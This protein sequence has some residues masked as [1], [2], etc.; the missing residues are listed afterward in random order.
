MSKG[1]SLVA[2]LAATLMLFSASTARADNS[3]LVAAYG[4]E[5]TSG[6]A[7]ADVTGTNPGTITGATRSTAGRHGSALSFDG[8]N[9]RVDIADSAS[10]DL[11]SGMTLEAW[12]KPTT[13]SDWRTAILKERA[14]GLAYA[15]YSSTDNSRPSAEISRGSMAET[16]GPS[17]LP[18]GTW[19]HLATTYDGANLRLYVNGTAVSSAAAP[20]AITVSTGALRLGGNNVWGEFFSGLIDEVRVYNRAL[21]AS[22]LATDMTTPVAVDAEAPT[23]PALTAAVQTGNDVLLTWTAGTD[24]VGVARYD[25]YRGDTLLTQRA[26]NLSRQWLDFDRPAGTASYRVVAVDAAGNPSPAGTAEATIA[27]DITPPAVELP[28]DCTG[29]KLAH[30]QIE[31][32][33]LVSDEFGTTQVRLELDGQPLHTYSGGGLSYGWNTRTATDGVH[34][35]KAIARDAAGNEGN[36]TC[37]YK[38]F[39]PTISVAIIAPEANATVHGD[40]DFR[41]EV[42]GNGEPLPTDGWYGGGTPVDYVDFRLNSAALRRVAEAPYAFTMSMVPLTPGTFPLTVTATINSAWA[43]SAPVTATTT[44]TL[45]RPPAPT[46]VTATVVDDNDVKLTWDAAPAGYGIQYWRV[47]RD[48]W[49]ISSNVS[50]RTF[51]DTD[52][53]PGTYRYTV[54]AGNGYY[55]G[56]H[57]EPIDVTVG[58]DA[59]PPT[60]SL[61][62][63]CTGTKRLFGTRELAP[64]TSD[65]VGVTQVRFELDGA[66]LHTGSTYQW[67]T[68]T[69]ADGVHTIKAIARDAAGNEASASCQYNTYNPDYSITVTPAEGSTV[70]GMVTHTATVLGDGEPL[71]DD[72]WLDGSPVQDVEL[73]PP[74]PGASPV[75]D[76]TA[77]YALTPWDTSVMGSRQQLTIRATANLVGGG[78]VTVANTFVADNSIPAPTGLT[79]TVVNGDDVKLTWDP[80]PSGYGIA[81]WRVYRDGVMLTTTTLTPTFTDANR[82]PG[83]YR[84]QV[85]AGNG[86]FGGDFA[87]VD[88]TVAGDT[89]P[90]TLSGLACS[91][92]PAQNTITFRPTYADESGGVTLTIK[93][94]GTTIYEGSGGGSPLFNW[95]SRT[96]ANGT[97]TLSA[98]ARDTAGNET[99]FS[100][101]F[102]VQNPVLSIPF[103]APADGATV[104]GQVVVSAQPREDNQPIQFVGSVEFT[105]ASGLGTATSSPWQRTWDTTQV[106]NGSYTL[107]AKAYRGTATTASATSTR[108]V[109]VANVVPKPTGLAAT[110]IDGNDVRLTWNAAPASSGALVYDVYRGGSLI[111]IANSTFLDLDR[112]AGTHRYTLVARNGG[113]EVSVVSDELAVTIDPPAQATGLVAEYAMD[114]APGTATGAVPAAGGKFGGA[115]SFDG[116]GDFITIPDANPFDLQPGMTLEAWVKPAAVSDWRTVLL[117]ERPGQLAYALYAAADGGPW[118]EVT[119]GTQRQANSATAIPVNAWTHL[120]AT[121]DKSTL[122]LYVNGTQVASAAVTGNLF[123]SAGPLKIGGNGIWGEWFSG[124]IDEVRVYERALTGAEIQS[125]LARPVAAG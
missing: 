21:S 18:A 104:S 55:G 122:R 44:I 63:D 121:Y 81:Y 8:I 78:T 28:G 89:T 92:T 106:A 39:N 15:L 40:V 46:G 5:E 72:G 99:P 115:F 87:T 7:A 49:Q 82:A 48:G 42:R 53:P 100:C 16:R 91:P 67:D 24:N 59:T 36:D 31:L 33:P 45:A 17:A 20:G 110:I 62:G 58:A 61:P 97:H 9:D 118:A 47:Y 107:T 3:G 51:T 113:G 73:T 12:V 117:K 105:G 83:T 108:Q 76:S 103:T 123:N 2:I 35:I 77:P 1:H 41:A 66:P 120:A 34:T 65:N 6:A 13:S 112:P 84:Y 32:A 119:A 37:E 93:V 124:L 43:P 50:G 64:Q 71:P 54:N 19:T 86:R 98:V 102:S 57:S 109:T 25:V 11:T 10:L 85:N 30:D 88:V 69:V 22:E 27:A 101:S 70:R 29:T 79:A 80:W 96:V 56:F 125:D 111:G 52:R 75:T 38:V 95:N 116:N 94:D 90:P 26:A 60:V 14:G 23:A 74:W 68:K 4:F 114:T